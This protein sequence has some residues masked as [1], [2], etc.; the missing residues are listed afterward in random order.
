M[1]L[2]ICTQNFN[3]TYFVDEN[4]YITTKD[5]KTPSGQWILYG[6]KHK[7]RNE[8]L[9]IEQYLK[10]PQEK[11]YYKNGN[12]Q[13]HVVDI[14]HNTMRIWTCGNEICCIAEGV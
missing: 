13:Y 7:R 1:K 4:N 12:S 10:L 5:V 11:R 3:N 2:T 9:S 6:F 14:D 8:L